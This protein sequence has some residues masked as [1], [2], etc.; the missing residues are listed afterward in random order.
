[1]RNV[2]LS[3][4]Y[5]GN[6]LVQAQAQVNAYWSAT[7]YDSL[8]GAV[9]RMFT[10]VIQI[11]LSVLV[12][13][14]FIRKQAGWVI[15]AIIYHAIVDAA[16]LVVL[17]LTNAYWVEALVGVFALISLAIIFSLRTPEP[18]P[19]A[20]EAVVIAPVQKPDSIEPSNEQLDNSKYS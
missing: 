15:V 17:Q 4:L 8:L 7:W 12:L 20:N 19:E 9:E 3:T 13:Q 11:S 10:V 1:M 6:T 14:A 5:T 16:A 2:D 18:E